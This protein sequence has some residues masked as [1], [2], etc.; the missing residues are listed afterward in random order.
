M[1]HKWSID[2]ASASMISIRSIKSIGKK[3]A[4]RC[5]K[6]GSSTARHGLFVTD[7]TKLSNKGDL[8]EIRQ[9]NQKRGS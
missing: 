1:E 2:G 6:Q 5:P 8:G 4:V 7:S 9:W 3:R